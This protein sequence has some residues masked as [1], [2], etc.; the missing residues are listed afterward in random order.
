MTSTISNGNLG[1]DEY[2]PKRLIID[3]LEANFFKF[4]EK[5]SNF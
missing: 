2:A 5:F 1:V 3:G 4:L